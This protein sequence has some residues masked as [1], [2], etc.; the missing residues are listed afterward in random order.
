MALI[1]PLEPREENYKNGM[2]SSRS[3]YEVCSAMKVELAVFPGKVLSSVP[4]VA[5]KLSYIVTLGKERTILPS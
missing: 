3:N 2:P 4:E 5:I 1:W